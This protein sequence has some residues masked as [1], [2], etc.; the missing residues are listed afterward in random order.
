MAVRLTIVAAVIRRQGKLLLTS[1]PA[2][3]PPHGL[4]FPG[5][6]VEAGETLAR[7]LCR[8][9][10]EE[11]GIADAVVLDPVYRTGTD[12]LEIWF[13]RTIVSPEQTVVCREGQRYFWIDP[14]DT[15]VT[16]KLFS[17]IPLLANDLL[18]WKF[19]RE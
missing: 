4:E 10:E 1:R 19:L 15:Q 3:K 16:G 2:D 9:L 13:M 12:K 14:D 6:K 17:E 5:G 8:E 18:F 7:A 11:L